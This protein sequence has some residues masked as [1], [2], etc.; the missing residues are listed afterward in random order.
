[1]DEQTKDKIIDQIL[2]S[3]S[4]LTRSKLKRLS[5]DR[6]CSL[7]FELRAFIDQIQMAQSE[8]EREELEDDE[9]EL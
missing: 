5:I 1:M 3:F 4:H 6:L 2:E 8:V 7:L 9:M